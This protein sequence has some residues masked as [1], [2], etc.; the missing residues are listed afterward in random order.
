MFAVLTIV[1]IQITGSLS[2]PLFA[3]MYFTASVLAVTTRG[4]VSTTAFLVLFLGVAIPEYGEILDTPWKTIM[5]GRFGAAFCCFVFFL[6]Y[7]RI[8]AKRKHETLGRIRRFEDDFKWIRERAVSEPGGLSDEE[9]DR[10]AVKTLASID[11]LLYELLQTSRRALS[12]NTIAYLVYASKENALRIR[13]ASS[14]DDEFDFESRIDLEIF[15]EA[16]RRGTPMVFRRGLSGYGIEP[17]YYRKSPSGINSLVVV[18]IRGES[19]TTGALVADRRGDVFLSERDIPF[20]E[21]TAL[22]LKNLEEQRIDMSRLSVSIREL[23]HLFGVSQELSR[24]KRIHEVFDVVSAAV[25]NLLPTRFMAFSL[26]YGEESFIADARGSDAKKVLKKRFSNENT[27]I[28]WVLENKQYL[29]FP[30]RQ[31]HRDVFGKN[32]PIKTEGALTIFPLVTEDEILGTF[33]QISE[34][35]IPPSRFHLR[36]IEVMVN[37][38]AVTLMNL[39]LI[40]RLN[41]MAVTDPMTGLFNR[42]RFNRALEDEIVRAQRFSEPITLLIL[43]IDKFKSINDTYGHAAGD[44][45]IK[46]VAEVLRE[47][48]RSV[49]IVSRIGGEE[50]SVLLPKTAQQE[51]MQ[52]AEKIR[53]T[54]EKRQFRLGG[55]SRAITI[56]VGISVFPQDGTEADPLVR[57]A[58]DNLYRA[59]EGGRNRC[60][61]ST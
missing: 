49:D 7:H 61:A 52:V 50:F 56:S 12:L 41:R 29:V 3:L 31:R 44:E 6:L 14:E 35:H 2:S 22:A 58:D 60:V 54:M 27:L 47:V 23:E 18:P 33:T 9:I 30:D 34:S 10:Q 39:R 5:L 53:K 11:D 55:G 26:L 40:N 25:E 45:V 32:I 19:E 59:K 24:V 38:S 28:G 51:G 36:L 21:L 4:V 16:M 13:E 8:E 20:L 15:R 1:L 17:G 42:R 37:M 48:T 46:G 43:D 57:C